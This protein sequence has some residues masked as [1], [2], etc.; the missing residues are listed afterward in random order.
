MSRNNDEK[1][2]DDDEGKE[3]KGS[4]LVRF[5]TFFYEKKKILIRIL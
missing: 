5:K 2:S 1:E 4:L 3:P